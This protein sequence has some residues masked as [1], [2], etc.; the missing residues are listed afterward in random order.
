MKK[1]T[2]SAAETPPSSSPSLSRSMHSST[3]LRGPSWN[4]MLK[5][6]LHAHWSEKKTQIHTTVLITQIRNQGSDTYRHKLDI[7]LHIF[8][9]CRGRHL[10]S[11]EHYINHCESKQRYKCIFNAA[12]K[13]YCVRLDIVTSTDVIK[14]VFSIGKRVINPA[15][16]LGE[17][18]LSLLVDR[19]MGESL[20]KQ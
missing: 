12:C 16:S 18:Q 9:D 8:N 6:A 4:K 7:I 17:S 5:S 10:C 3:G 14:S 1:L 2:V 13:H 20:T 15:N 11:V 19:R